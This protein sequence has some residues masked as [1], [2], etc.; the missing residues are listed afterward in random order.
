MNKLYRQIK[1]NQI[2]TIAP[3][4]KVTGAMK[5][6]DNEIDLNRPFY[7]LQMHDVTHDVSNSIQYI[8]QVA[9]KMSQSEKAIIY[10][11]EFGV[12]SIFHK[13]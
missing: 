4:K 5:S 8:L 2:P 1:M 11:N 9:G 6:A 7:E 13:H 3:P 10:K 12:K